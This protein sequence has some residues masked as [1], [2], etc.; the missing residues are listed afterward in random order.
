MFLRFGLGYSYPHF[1]F[2]HLSFCGFETQS[3]RLQFCFQFLNSSLRKLQL[4]PKFTFSLACSMFD[5]LNDFRHFIDQVQRRTIACRSHG[6]SRFHRF[7]G[8]RPK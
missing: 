2:T 6:R 7:D 4:G 8:V 1:K 3:L 5:A